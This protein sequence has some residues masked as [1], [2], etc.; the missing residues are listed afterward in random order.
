[1]QETS[2]HEAQDCVDRELRMGIDEL[3]QGQ[4]RVEEHVKDLCNRVEWLEEA[5]RGNGKPGLNQRLTSI[6]EQLKRIEY[7]GG[8]CAKIMMPMLG[9]ILLGGITAFIKTVV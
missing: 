6:E 3:L 1:M 5:V 9:A 2:I 8:F 7:W 4:V